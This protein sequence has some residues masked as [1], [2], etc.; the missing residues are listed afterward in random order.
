MKQKDIENLD[1]QF[2]D[3]SKK[4]KVQQEIERCQLLLEKDPTN[5]DLHIK[6]IS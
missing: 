3:K 1:R 2:N 4:S 6:F 5:P